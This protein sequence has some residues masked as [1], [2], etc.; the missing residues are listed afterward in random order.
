[1]Q[2]TSF[3]AF[4]ERILWERKS[5]REMFIVKLKPKESP[6]DRRFCIVHHQKLPL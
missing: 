1:M 4:Q 2:I 5:F 6:E 3:F